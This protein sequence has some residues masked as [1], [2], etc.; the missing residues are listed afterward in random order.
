M[1]DDTLP[2]RVHEFANMI[3]AIAIDDRV[4]A[5]GCEKQLD[6]TLAHKSSKVMSRLIAIQTAVQMICYCI[7]KPCV[8]I[9]PHEI[10]KYH[11][12]P[13]RTGDYARNKQLAVDKCIELYGEQYGKL[14]HHIC[15]AKLTATAAQHFLSVD[16]LQSKSWW[17]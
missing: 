5:I 6:A 11:K 8:L 10:K 15:D 9:T 1:S 17:V 3:A 4:T 12:M 2:Q 13:P 7:R 16:Q 14:V